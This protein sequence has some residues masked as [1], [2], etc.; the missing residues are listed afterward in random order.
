MSM[1]NWS[2][3]AKRPN[4]YPN[5]NLTPEGWIN[6]V[7]KSRYSDNKPTTPTQAELL[8]RFKSAPVLAVKSRKNRKSRRKNRKSRKN[9]R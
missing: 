5:V 2:S 3:Y 8:E 4:V 7:K 6:A 9:R 1:S